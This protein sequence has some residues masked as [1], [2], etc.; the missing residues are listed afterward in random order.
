MSTTTARNRNAA[1]RPL[2]NPARRGRHSDLPDAAAE[3]GIVSSARSS[4]AT[5]RGVTLAEFEEYLRT[6]NNRDGRPY[7]ETINAYVAPGRNLDA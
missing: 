6:V 3:T 5:E 7:A 1:S 4:G 2:K